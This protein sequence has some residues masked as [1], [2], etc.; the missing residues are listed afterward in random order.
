LFS[1][2]RLYY[3][4]HHYWRTY[5]PICPPI[6]F[7]VTSYCI[8]YCSPYHQ[9]RRTLLVTVLSTAVLISTYDVRY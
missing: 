3:H 1:L 8:I 2:L 5:T 4:H 7:Q 9:L 6:T